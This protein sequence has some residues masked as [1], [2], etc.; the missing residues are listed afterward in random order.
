MLVGEG[1]KAQ[2][3]RLRSRD[4]WVAALLFALF[5]PPVMRL[6]VAERQGLGQELVTLTGLLA[7]SLLVCTVILP[8]RLR[9]LTRDFGIEAV[10]R[11]HRL[12]GLSTVLLVLIH[13][14]AVIVNDPRG[15][16]LMIP[17]MNPR[18]PHET[19]AALPLLEPLLSPPGRAMAGTVATACLFAVATVSSR[20]IKR[21]ET[22]RAWHVSLAAIAL[23][24]TLTH[25]LL[26]GHLFPTTAVVAVVAGDPLGWPLL[27]AALVD[28]YGAAYLVLLGLVV[29]A[30]AVR[31]WMSLP[32][33]HRYRVVKRQSLSESVSKLVLRPAHNRGVSFRPGQFAW[34]RLAPDRLAEEHPFTV[35]SAEQDLPDIEFTIRHLGDFT[36]QLRRLGPGDEV[37]LDGP[38]GSFTPDLRSRTGLV[39]IAAGVGIAPMRAI[40]RAAA[41]HKHRRRYAIRLFYVDRPGNELYRD[42]LAELTRDMDLQISELGS[43]LTP[44]LL[45]EQLPGSFVRDRFD[46]YVCGPPALVDDT[47][48]ALGALHIPRSRI[49]TE[50]FNI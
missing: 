12:L 48:V 36:H 32:A 38:H 1:L 29:F 11:S 15:V 21:Y 35:S 33:W 7:T 50:Q 20:R 25:I 16:A 41:S 13:I 27:R 28:P 37:W 43:R 5:A 4:A 26:I 49:N 30:V 24:T 34:L 10:L 23:I 9:S 40:L 22:W 42:E 2:V 14:A 47:L 39:L 6:F 8:S 19:V 45:A 18:Q 31:R 46:Y 17:F 3:I 44:E